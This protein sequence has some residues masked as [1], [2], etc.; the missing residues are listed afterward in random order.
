MTAELHPITAKSLPERF[1]LGEFCVDLA[2]NTISSADR[3]IRLTPKSAGVLRELATHAGRAVRRDSLLE[4]VWAGAYPTDDVLSHCVTELRRAMNDDPR[5]SRVIETI[6]KVGYRLLLL[7]EPAPLADT[8]PGPDRRRWRISRSSVL[9]LL[10]GAV[11]GSL[12]TLGVVS[13]RPQAN[14]AAILPAPLSQAVPLTVEPGQER[15]PAVSADGRQIVYAAQAGYGSSYDLFIRSTGADQAIRFTATDNANELVPVWSPDGQEVAFFRYSKNTCE[16]IIKPLVGG[17]ERRIGDCEPSAITYLDWSPDGK[18]LA[19]TGPIEY[20]QVGG[21]ALLDVKSGEVRSLPYDKARSEHDVQPKFS[22]DGE[23][24]MF[25]RGAYPRSDLYVLSRD[26]SR[27]TQLT[28][29]GSQILG[30]DWLPDGKQAWFCSD[31]GGRNTMW[32]LDVSTRRVQLMEI[33]CPYMLSIARQA[34][35]MAYQHVTVDPSLI[36]VDLEG[37]PSVD[38]RFVSTRIEA[39]PSYDPA[40]ERVVFVSD[41]SGDNQLWIGSR[42]SGEVF[43]LTRHQGMNLSN[44]TW[45]PDARE[46]YYVGRSGSGEAMYSVDVSSGIVNRLSD[47]TERVRSVSVSRDGASVLYASNRSGDWQIWRL[48]RASGERTQLTVNGGT[49]PVDPLDDGWVYYTKLSVYGLWRIPLAGGE[50]ELVTHLVEFYNQD[51]WVLNERGIFLTLIRGQAPSAIYRI[52]WTPEAN[53]ELI[54]PVTGGTDVIHLKDV[55][56]DGQRL[57]LVRW[58]NTRQDIMVSRDW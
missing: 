56:R 40:G 1:S 20:S 3:E 11:L 52:P 18:E 37:G 5:E 32:Q 22:P 49:L 44:P 8:G 38:V 7:P 30:Y 31:Y 57:L 50:E 43:Q 29:L 12:A 53:P 21:V 16:L 47:N 45:T 15:M 48:D 14:A 55:S 46:V 13:Q 39:E 9:W 23:Q 17:F 51:S 33:G 25:R 54:A 41:R 34:N 28:D 19:I 35:V 10:A 6:P 27:L 24:I 2:N 36:E 42:D 4:A 58:Q 26:G